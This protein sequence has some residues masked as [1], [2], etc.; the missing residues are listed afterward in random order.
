MIVKFLGLFDL[1]CV[2]CIVAFAW[3]PHSIVMK[4]GMLLMFKGIVFATFKDIPSILDALAGLYMG[5]M[6]YGIS[7]PLIGGFFVIFL[8]VKGVMSLFAN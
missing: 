3:I 2:L 6:V 8:G 4:I 7:A 5:L 1:I